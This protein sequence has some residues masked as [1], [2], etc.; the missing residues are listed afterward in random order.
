MLVEFRVRV[1]TTCFSVLGTFSPEKLRFRIRRNIQYKTKIKPS[2][3]AL[4][5]RQ[6][7]VKRGGREEAEPVQGQSC[8]VSGR[9][10]DQENTLV[11]G[12]EIVHS[13]F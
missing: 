3:E 1:S 7:I 2:F 9:S 12:R 10:S 11:L 6:G 5:C 4:K 13:C 8:N